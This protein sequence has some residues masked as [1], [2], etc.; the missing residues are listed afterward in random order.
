[1]IFI[2]PGKIAPGE[3]LSQPV[4]MIDMLPTILD[5]TDLPMPEVMQGQSLAPLLL[6]EEGWEQRPVIFDEFYLDPETGE[7]SGN[8]E[9]VDGRWG[10]SL[11]IGTWIESQRMHYQAQPRPHRLLLYDVWDDPYCLV[12]LNDKHSDLVE[13]YTKFLE[14]QWEARQ[15]LGKL[16]SRS[17]KVPLTPEQIETLRSLGYIR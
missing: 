5:L 10:A 1:M 17:G 13:K 14:E 3:R 6:G 4:S 16:F 8:I 11:R 2:W 7:L 9:V 12:H 15:A